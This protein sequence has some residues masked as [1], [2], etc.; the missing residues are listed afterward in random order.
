MLKQSTTTFAAKIEN[1][2]LAVKVVDGIE[3]RRIILRLGREFDET[4]ASLLGRDS[5]EVLRSL[6][7]RSLEKGY[8]SA[9]KIDVEATFVSPPGE[10]VKVPALRGQTAVL[11]A[12]RDPEDGPSIKLESECVFERETWA[13]LGENAAGIVEVTMTPR[14]GEL[15]LAEQS[16]KK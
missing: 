14:Q 15:S 16:G 11:T 5:S 7:S 1:V 12:G 4:M 13:F 3:F 2:Q 10:T 6:R 9:D 8:V